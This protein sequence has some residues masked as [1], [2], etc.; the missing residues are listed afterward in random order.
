ML[1]YSLILCALLGACPSPPPV[2]PPDEPPP[3][4][5]GIFSL[6]KVHQINLEIDPQLLPQLDIDVNT[7]VPADI[8]FDG[9]SVENIGIRKKCGLSSCVSIT[10]KTG[11]SIKFDEFDETLRL[12]GRKKLILNNTIQDPSYSNE[13][14]GQEVARR[15]GIPAPLVAYASV[16]LNGSP[17][18]FFVMTEAID[19]Q[20]L[21]KHFGE[22]NDEGNLYEGPCCS[23]FVDNI[24]FP[25]LKDEEDGR[26]RD[27]LQAFSDFIIDS[28]DQQ[29]EARLAEFLDVDSYL[30]QYA[31]SALT[32]HIDNYE[33]NTNNYY[34]YHNPGDDTFHFW[35]HGMDFLFFDCSFSVDF[36]PFGFLGQRVFTTPSLQEGFHQ[37]ITRIL[38]EVWSDDL[39]TF[40]DNTRAMYE[41]EARLDPTRPFDDLLFNSVRQCI[42][43]RPAIARTQF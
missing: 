38:D 33:Y 29:F 21:R 27:D 24:F 11:F 36:V 37:E 8:T 15:A 23:D 26:T 10:D 3:E 28:D 13:L 14:I 1:R 9:I 6:D 40:L 18:G 41:A 35:L 4:D 25:E 20:F 43:D 19:K 5:P 42:V 22:Q 30:T 17:Y 39:L 7:R 12:G 34:S 31:V 32:V 2:I 16:T